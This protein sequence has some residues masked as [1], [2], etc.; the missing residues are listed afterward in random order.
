MRILVTGGS[1]FIG[2]AIASLLLKE[3]HNV[4]I[5]DLK[6]PALDVD[7]VEGSITDPTI[8][9]KAIEDCDAVVHL[10]AILGVAFTDSNPVETLDTSINGIKNVLNAAKKHGVKR[11]LF[12]SSS[13]VYGE[14]IKLPITEDEPLKPKSVYGVGKLASEWY[15]RAFSKQHGLPYTIVRFFNVYGPRQAPNWVVAR[16]VDL[17]LKNEPLTIYGKGDQIRAF[18]Y[19]EDIA[20]GTV[21]AL[22]SEKGANNEFNIGNGNEPIT[23]LEL[24]KKIIRLSGSRSEIKMV[25]IEVNRTEQREI[26]KRVPDTNKARTVLAYS[27]KI[28]LDDG[29]NKTI[30][31]MRGYLD[32]LRSK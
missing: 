32:D 4:R 28:R 8:V 9:D 22:T 17:A 18:C 7:F 19:V 26:E 10:A 30:G 20:R 11:V 15:L 14:P 24:A 5:L 21:L 3:G 23:M 31:W 2:T 12:S 25:P 6:R 27:P 16:F 13:E 1:G 29:L